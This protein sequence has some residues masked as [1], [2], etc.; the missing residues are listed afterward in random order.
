MLQC[1]L[2]NAQSVRD[3]IT[4]A[5]SNLIVASTLIL[6]ISITLLLSV[7]AK[8]SLENSNRPDML[9]PF[10][11]IQMFIITNYTVGITLTVAF[12]SQLQSCIRDIDIIDYLVIN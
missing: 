11:Y 1:I 9:K 2:F 12:V 5:L 7:G 8:D 10:F 6:G 3:R 4:T